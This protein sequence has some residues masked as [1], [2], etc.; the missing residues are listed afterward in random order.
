MTLSD[1]DISGAVYSFCPEMCGYL[2]LFVTSYQVL[3]YFT[4]EWLSIIDH[5]S[6]AMFAVFYP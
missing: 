4:H 6:F 5:Q 1:I 3:I 2:G